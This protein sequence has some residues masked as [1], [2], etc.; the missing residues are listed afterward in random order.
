MAVPQYGEEFPEVFGVLP[1]ELSQHVQVQF[2]GDLEWLKNDDSVIVSVPVLKNAFRWLLTHNWHWILATA[3]DTI[4]FDE[5]NYGPR[6]NA[7]LCAYADDLDGKSA[8]VPKSVAQVATPLDSKA[9][10]QAQPGPAEV[11]SEDC[12]PTMA[13][14]ALLGSGASSTLAMQHTERRAHGLRGR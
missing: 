7:L 10:A 12:P 14:A 13:S 4:D 8:G 11:A 2:E 5:D 1:E 6:L 9:A 3:G